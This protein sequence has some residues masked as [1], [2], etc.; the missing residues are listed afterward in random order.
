[1]AAIKV[2][3]TSQKGGV[4]KSTLSANLSA[5]LADVGHKSVCLVDFDHQGSSSEWVKQVPKP[6][7]TAI[8][9]DALAE[10]DPMVSVLKMKQTIRAAERTHDIVL[11]D[12]TWVRF[13]PQSFVLDFD[14]VLVPT[15]ISQVELSS[16]MEF[17]SQF[18]AM[19]NSLSQVAPKLVVVPTRMHSTK[20]YQAIFE[21]SNFPVRFALSH[22]ISFDLDVQHLFAKQ[23]MYELEHSPVS[24]GF[25]KVAQD[26]QQAFE[27]K[28]EVKKRFKD[29]N[30]TS[31]WESRKA[32]NSRPTVLDKFSLQ[33][34]SSRAHISAQHAAM[35][36]NAAEPASTGA[37]DKI[38]GLFKKAS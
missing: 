22:P 37:L 30:I 26:L 38:M 14:F 16:T 19:F 7:L 34:R 9:C 27:Q 33:Q 31:I 4:G 12:L 25:Q 36:V 15:S 35:Q 2:L 32:L 23:Y 13:F 3:V 10:R 20:D 18:N 29:E 8:Y 1:M 21:Q 6:G 28:S 11:A 17:V 24:I 5:F